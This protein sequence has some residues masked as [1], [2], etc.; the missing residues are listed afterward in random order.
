MDIRTFE[1]GVLK[2]V[3]HQN[4]KIYLIRT[5]I[6]TRGLPRVTESADYRS[7]FKISKLKRQFQYGELICKNLFYCVWNRCSLNNFDCIKNLTQ[8]GSYDELNHTQNLRVSHNCRG[9]CETCWKQAFSLVRDITEPVERIET[10]FPPLHFVEKLL[11]PGLSGY[12]VSGIPNPF[13]RKSLHTRYFSPCIIMLCNRYISYNARSITMWLSIA[14]ATIISSVRVPQEPLSKCSTVTGT[15]F[16][17]YVPITMTR[18]NASWEVAN[19]RWSSIYLFPSPTIFFFVNFPRSRS[20]IFREH[21]PFSDLRSLC[22]FKV[23]QAPFILVSRWL[24][25][26][27][28]DS[29]SISDC[30]ACTSV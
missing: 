13:V 8:Y 21:W 6:R 22:A 19:V 11:V 17:S 9:K 15:E 3:D 16:F 10:L 29:R 30:V 28:K 25:W 7:W 20:A 2:I 18:L 1:Y 26:S 24:V 23:S 5:K 14:I 12:G 4:L 27:F